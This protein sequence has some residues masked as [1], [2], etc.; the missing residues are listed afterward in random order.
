MAKRDLIGVLLKPGAQP[1]KSIDV[2]AKTASANG[3]AVDLQ[4]Y[5]ACVMIV[6]ADARTDGTHTVRLEE[7]DDNSTFSAV[8]AADLS[9]DS[10]IG[11]VNAS[12]QVVIDGAADDDQACVV[13]YV[14]AKRYVRAA[15]VVTSA[16]TGAIYGALLVPGHARHQGIDLMA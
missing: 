5:E 6:D 14:G 9:W 15:A 10:A 13:G 2:G 8:A 11:P 7:S 1:T 4:G 16:T 12:G 3:A